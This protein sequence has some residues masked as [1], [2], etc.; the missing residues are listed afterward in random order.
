LAEPFA[1]VEA[2]P[3][4]KTAYVSVINWCLLYTVDNT[5]HGTG[6]EVAGLGMTDNLA[7]DTV[8]LCSKRESDECNSVQV[9][10]VTS[11]RIKATV[12]NE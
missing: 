2:H 10:E 6:I 7:T 1:I 9:S 12:A 8:F 3:L 5:S 11:E 4:V